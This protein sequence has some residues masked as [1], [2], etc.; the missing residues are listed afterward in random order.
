MKLSIINYI[1]NFE[2]YCTFNMYELWKY[3]KEWNLEVAKLRRPSTVMLVAII[4]QQTL[5]ACW[6]YRNT[7]GMES[8]ND[9]NVAAKKLNRVVL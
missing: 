6:F 4:Y 3:D 5:T 7:I 2:L 1:M 9:A 8:N